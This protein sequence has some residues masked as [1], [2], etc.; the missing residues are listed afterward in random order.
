MNA[1]HTDL[2]IYYIP[3]HLC[4]AVDESGVPIIG[5]PKAE[6]LESPL[7]GNEALRACLE[8]ELAFSILGDTLFAR[9]RFDIRDR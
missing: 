8:L 9:D 6:F 5:R 2:G 1:F 4:T 3:D 7:R